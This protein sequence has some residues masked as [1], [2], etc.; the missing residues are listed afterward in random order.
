MAPHWADLCFCWGPEADADSSST[1]L[2]EAPALYGCAATVSSPQA[3]RSRTR[4][5]S[6]CTGHKWN[7]HLPGP[8]FP[9]TASRTGR[10]G[11]H[12]P[13]RPAS[14]CSHSQAGRKLEQQASSPGDPH[15][16]APTCPQARV[17][18]QNAAT[19][20]EAGNAADACTGETQRNTVPRTPRTPRPCHPRN[21]APN[22]PAR[23]CA[24]P[25]AS[26]AL[27]APEPAARPP[28]RP[29]CSS[30]RAPPRCAAGQGHGGS[31]ASPPPRRPSRCHDTPGR[32]AVPGQGSSRLGASPSWRPAPGR[33]HAPPVTTRPGDHGAPGR[34]AGSR[35]RG[36]Q[37]PG[38][39][40]AL[41]GRT[42]FRETSGLAGRPSSEGTTERGP[43]DA[44][45]ARGRCAA[46]LCRVSRDHLERPHSPCRR[47]RPEP[48]GR[49]PGPREDRRGGADV[50][51]AAD[52]SLRA[53]GWGRGR[54]L[55]ALGGGVGA[56]T[57]VP[58]RPSPPPRPPGHP[59]PAGTSPLPAAE[60]GLR[61]PREGGRGQAAAPA[62]RTVGKGQPSTSALSRAAPPPAPPR[63]PSGRS[64]E[65][66]TISASG[67]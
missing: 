30:S 3:G 44:R 7:P 34:G 21:P 67:T 64:R 35:S 19:P 65:P 52:P 16:S 56:A 57:P 31:G 8:C 38:E 25:A 62:L 41:P 12:S 9:V 55:R 24:P 51:P 60:R 18:Q 10:T 17:P 4:S 45:P 26:A 14:R 58:A 15:R 2:P 11:T 32:T 66:P 53:R 40:P 37:P 59:P 5:L 27:K 29:A 49:A 46:A 63:W 47:A 48:H 28:G 33:G 22:W 39:S 13:G 42:V 6:M 20:T 43:S 36:L 1:S 61:G 54:S 23:V 50:A